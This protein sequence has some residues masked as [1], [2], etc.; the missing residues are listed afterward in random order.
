VVLARKLLLL[1]WTLEFAVVHGIHAACLR[2][3]RFILASVVCSAYSTLQHSSCLSLAS[4]S[5]LVASLTALAALGAFANAADEPIGTVIGIDL[6]AL[7]AYHLLPLLKARRSISA[8]AV[9][10][11]RHN[12]TQLSRS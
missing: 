11:V 12:E 1:Q 9:T 7:R 2:D 4:D 10:C 3:R 8:R 6:G 5:R